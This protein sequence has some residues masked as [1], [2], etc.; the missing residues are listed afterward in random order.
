MRTLTAVLTAA[1]VLAL[2]AAASAYIQVDQGIA[3]ARVGN[4]QAQVKA[5]LGDPAHVQTGSNDFGDYTN[6]VYEGGLRVF[7]Q[8]KKR[9]TSVVALGRGDRTTR[10]VGVGSSE[11]TV[12]Q[13][14]K[15]VKCETTAGT[16]SCHTGEFTPGSRVT[17]FRIEKGRVTSV[18]IGDV[19]D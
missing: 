13:K 6:F 8:G 7:F 3:G 17:D 4:T 12:K 1:A 9:V 16:R 15:G 2:P 11:K 10:G 14:V 18:T 5:A 19:L